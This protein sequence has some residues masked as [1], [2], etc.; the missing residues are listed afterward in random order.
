MKK[1]KNPRL[2]KDGDFV[3]VREQ[4]PARRLQVV[5]RSEAYALVVEP[6]HLSLP[7]SVILIARIQMPLFPRVSFGNLSL[8]NRAEEMPCKDNSCLMQRCGF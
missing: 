4:P 7:V 5:E 2:V 1:R 6:S 8:T 3:L